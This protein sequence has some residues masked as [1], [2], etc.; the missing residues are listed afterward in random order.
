MTWNVESVLLDV[1]LNE[2]VQHGMHRKQRVRLFGFDQPGDE[3]VGARVQELSRVRSAVIYQPEVVAHPLGPMRQDRV[4]Q[5]TQR[6]VELSGF[7]ERF[8]NGDLESC[9]R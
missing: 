9:R 5:A 8:S 4:V 2:V 1:A 7:F 3:F 6:L